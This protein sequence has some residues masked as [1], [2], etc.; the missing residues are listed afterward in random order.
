M[1]S[2]TTQAAFLIEQSPGRW[3]GS[4]VEFERQ[5]KIKRMA[6]A[7]CG[8]AKRAASCQ[9]SGCAKAKGPTG[10]SPLPKNTLTRPV[11]RQLS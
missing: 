6:T 10:Q 1:S 9:F 3:I 5:D 8:S 7:L 4:C 2:K 11:K